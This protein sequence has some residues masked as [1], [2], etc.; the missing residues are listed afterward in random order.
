MSTPRLVAT[1]AAG[2]LCAATALPALAQIQPLPSGL[3][4]FPGSNPSPA[5]ARSAG[6]ALADRWLGDDPY[7][8]PAFAAPG[9]VSATPLLLNLGRE[10]LRAANR[11]YTDTAA[12]FDAAGGSVRLA[13][14]RWS[15]ALYAAQP[16][17]RLE[18]NTFTHGEVGDPTPPAQL[19]SHAVSREARVGLALSYRSDR[20]AVGVAPEWTYRKD[21]LRTT[22]ASGGP[23]TG[24]RDLQWSGSAFGVQAGARW[25]MP[26]DSPGRVRVGVGVRYVPALSLDGSLV[27]DL[28]ADTSS[29]D[30]HV[31]RASG[32]E[33]GVSIAARLGA[34]FQAFAGAG[35]ATA[36]DWTGAGVRAGR[37]GTWSAGG[38]YHDVRDPWTVRFGVGMESHEGTP[39]P[40]AGIAGLGFAWVSG[41]TTYDL[42]VV[43]RSLSGT[44]AP[45]SFDNRVVGTVTL[46]W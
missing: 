31:D 36:Q 23:T 14:P 43:R 46:A 30:V 4:A 27:Q 22:E 38:E 16:V 40:R 19:G 8:N 32:W 24:T 1:L 2:L 6:L 42:G 28:A 39:E 25:S 33:G 11:D 21:E 15:A 20:A 41:G 35:G 12:F 45:T 3:F 29:A 17:L 13:R 18:D 5:T 10:D 34:A 26:D 9:G 44:S 7:D 37:V